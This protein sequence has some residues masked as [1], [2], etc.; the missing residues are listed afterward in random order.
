MRSHGCLIHISRQLLSEL[1]SLELFSELLSKYRALMACKALV[2]DLG[3]AS[4]AK[5]VF[6][7]EIGLNREISDKR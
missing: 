6:F 4:S 7:L 5:R 1:L 2:I 3:G